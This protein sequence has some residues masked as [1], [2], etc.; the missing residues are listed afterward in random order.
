M[1]FYTSFMK[2][3]TCFLFLSCFL[4]YAE[5]LHA[6]TIEYSKSCTPP[7]ISERQGKVLKRELEPIITGKSPDSEAILVVK[8]KKK[9]AT[10]PHDIWDFMEKN[11]G[12]PGKSTEFLDKFLGAKEYKI[13]LPIVLYEPEDC[14]AIDNPEFGKNIENFIEKSLKKHARKIISEI[15]AIQ[16]PGPQVIYK[17][18]SY[19]A[20]PE[21][22]IAKKIEKNGVEFIPFTAK[23][24]GRIYKSRLLHERNSA[25]AN[26]YKA[27]ISIKVAEW[28]KQAV[29]PALQNTSSMKLQSKLRVCFREYSDPE[30]NGLT[31]KIYLFTSDVGF[32]EKKEKGLDCDM[33]EGNGCCE[34][35]RQ[36]NGKSYYKCQSNDTIRI[37]LVDEAGVDLI[38][39]E[40][41]RY[42]GSF[43]HWKSGALNSYLNIASR[44][45]FSNILDNYDRI[46]RS[47]MMT[48][49]S[50]ISIPD[51]SSE[52]DY[53]GKIE[54]YRKKMEELEN[55]IEKGS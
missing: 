42:V 51:A 1:K 9:A 55:R 45:V 22:T 7:R 29:I 23:F 3:I 5:Y 4:M 53:L 16:I 52:E 17:K 15:R 47:G 28:I 11:I 8:C 38:H 18:S 48:R 26:F 6:V 12:V 40:T 46:K 2:L 50:I 49:T 14:S 30:I 24:G 19:L 31:N 25:D 41:A 34:K 27:Q 21:I 43:E 44:E 54:N 20:D 36:A 37:Y 10:C 35:K 32:P 39:S 33:L 13:D